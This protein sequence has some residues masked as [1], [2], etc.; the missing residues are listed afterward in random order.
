MLDLK[1][2]SHDDFAACLNQPFT[3][4]DDAAG[5][6]ELELVEVATRGTFDPALQ[7][8]QSFAILFV[9]SAEP[10]L[11]QGI[12]RLH[13]DQLGAMDLFLVPV[14]LAAQ[15]MRYEAIFT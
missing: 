13:H 4:D 8:R 7:S 11:A 9:G 10:A 3:I 2:A 14:G 15:G 1:T 6:V 12:H 5:T